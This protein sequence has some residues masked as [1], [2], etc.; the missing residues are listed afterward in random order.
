MDWGEQEWKQSWIGSMLGAP[1]LVAA[2]DIEVGNAA[3]MFAVERRE[4]QDLPQEE[5]SLSST[6]PGGVP[7]G[8][9]LP[10]VP[11]GPAALGGPL[12]SVCSAVC[13]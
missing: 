6:I 4:S 3:Y 8:N 1:G 11:A 5:G 12:F 7:K 9:C 10:C 2:V 13:D